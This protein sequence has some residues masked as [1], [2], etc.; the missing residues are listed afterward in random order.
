[1]DEN[2][3]SRTISVPG[4]DEEQAARI[5][6]KTGIDSSFFPSSGL[7]S[8]KLVQW[9]DRFLDTT[10]YSM[11]DMPGL[12]LEYLF[13]KIPATLCEAE[14]FLKSVSGESISR[15]VVAR[16]HSVALALGSNTEKRENNLVK[17]VQ[18]LKKRKSFFCDLFSSLYE[19]P[20]AGFLQ[21]PPFYNMALLGRTPLSPRAL[22]SYV[23]EIEK[24]MGRGW[25]KRNRPRPIDIDIIYY[26]E[27]ICE[28][29]DL[30]IPHRERMKRDFVLLP[31][32]ELLGEFR[33]PETG[34]RVR[35][36]KGEG[37]HRLKS[38][39]DIWKND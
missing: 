9:T 28:E 29:K 30:R 4:A 35:A 24:D 37:I 36:G 16:L 15:R 34:R 1:M 12:L 11:D 10:A 23:K 21:Q 14:V 13:D 39:G 25:S 31:L 38:R 33:D 27:E 32:T 2:T 3:Y 17:A 7:S 8:E 22:L 19:S 18:E 5:S 26:D 20:P 6:V